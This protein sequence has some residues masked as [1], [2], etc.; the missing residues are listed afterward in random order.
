MCPHAPRETVCPNSVRAPNPKWPPSA[1]M[2]I[3]LSVVWPTMLYS[4]WFP[5]LSEEFIF[6]VVL[7]I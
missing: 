6:D 3:I 1:I 4:T 2:E 7:M 5:G